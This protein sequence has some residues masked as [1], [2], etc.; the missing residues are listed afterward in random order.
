MQRQNMQMF[1]IL[2]LKTG[3]KPMRLFGKL[4]LIG[5]CLAPS[6]AFAWREAGH[7]AVCEIASRHLSGAAKAEINRL[8]GGKDFAAQCT[9]PDMVRK[10]PEFKYTY[11][12]HFINLEDSQQY[13]EPATLNRKCDA[14]R[15]I[16]EA[17]ATLVQPG[18]TDANKL[19]ALRF[20]GHIV[21]DI[22]QPLHVGRKSDV[23][24]NNIKVSWFGSGTYTSVEILRA[25]L[26]PEGQCEGD[27]R[28]V[29]LATGECVRK[30]TSVEQASLHKTWDLL[31]VQ[32]FIDVERLAPE[33]NDSPYLHKALATR[34]DRDIT[35]ET[36]RKWQRS[37][38][39]D[40]ADDSRTYRL[41]P[42]AAL[43]TD[44]NVVQ[45]LGQE[46]Y[47][48]HIATLNSRILKAG[49]RLA[50]V[51]N[52]AFDSSSDTPTH[53]AFLELRGREL[54]ERMYN[55]LLAANLA[56]PATIFSGRVACPKP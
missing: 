50:G 27:D 23:G 21:G 47:D 17:Q 4:C 14:L 46:Y 43:G 20:L 49:Y 24:G 18:A 48:A 54:Q 30:T 7:F 45:P 42:Y 36:V 15:A 16:V 40:W 39:G 34:I 29:D 8:L 31:M 32:K 52:R 9:W 56:M 1:A 41:E 33:L 55:A 25:D 26:G 11:D 53:T 2:P 35:P 37:T 51:I 22:H 28:F 6:P 10:S 13:F 38:P 3:T 12:W 5:L 44:P 19:Q